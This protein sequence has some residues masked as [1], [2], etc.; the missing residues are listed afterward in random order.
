M[1]FRTPIVML[2]AVVALPQP[3]AAQGDEVLQ[4]LVIVSR[5]GVR[6]PTMAPAAT[7]ELGGAA[8]AG[9]EPAGG[10]AD[11]AR[12]PARDADGPLLPRV[13]RRAGRGARRRMSGAGRASTSTPTSPNGRRPPRR[14]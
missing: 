4:K 12:R 13:R 8:V 7:R 5:H 3:V 14:R 11:A 2:M 6:T 9:L 1:K 10:R